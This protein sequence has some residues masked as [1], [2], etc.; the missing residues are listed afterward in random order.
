MDLKILFV[1]LSAAGKTSIIRVLDE[2]SVEDL[3]PTYGI[4][5][6]RMKFLGLNIFRWDVGGQDLYRKQFFQQFDMNIDKTSLILFVV[7]IQDKKREKENLEFLSTL[8]G[9]LAET[10][11]SPHIGVLLHKMDPDIRKISKIR[12]Y[13]DSMETKCREI[14]GE[15]PH[16]FFRT[17]ITMITTWC[18]GVGSWEIKN[19]LCPFPGGLGSCFSR[20]CSG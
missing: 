12:K 18:S 5:M 17:S 2:E 4:E 13:S 8:C 10:E 7:D 3:Q 11:D 14:L 6:S 20:S 1:G 16:L 19:I 15:N 9:K